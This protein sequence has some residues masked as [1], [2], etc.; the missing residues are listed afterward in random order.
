MAVILLITVTVMVALVAVIVLPPPAPF[1]PFV[2]PDDAFRPGG[3]GNANNRL[4]GRQQLVDRHLRR[5]KQQSR[6]K[7]R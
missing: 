1:T 3:I 2:P 6:H 5:Q 7:T 4:S